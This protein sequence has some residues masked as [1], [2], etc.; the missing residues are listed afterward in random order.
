MRVRC[1]HCHN[2][3][4][5]V[6][7]S[8]LSDIPCPTCGSSFSLVGGTET[9]QTHG[10]QKKTLGHFELA[11][12][13]GVGAHGEVWR[14][15]DMRL[16]RTV[17]VKIPRK[18]RLNPDEAEKFLR[19]ARAAAQ[20]KHPSIVSVHE[21]GREDGQVYIVSDY[22]EG[23]TLADRLLIGPLSAHESARLCATIAAAL[24]H[25]HEAGVVHRDLKPSNI[26]LDAQN[27]PHVTDF[28]LAKREAG[29]ITM[30][31]AGQMLGTPAY[32]SPE[33][34]KGAAHD[35]DRRSDIYSLG[36]IV[37]ELLTGE[38][39]FRGNQRM[40][41]HQVINEDAPSPRKL[42]VSVPRDLE[43]ICLRCL[44][45]DPARRFPDAKELGDELRRFLNG[46]PIHSRP[47]GYTARAWR[48]CARNRVVSAA[49]ATVLVTLLAAFVLVTVAFRKERDARLRS[50][51]RFQLA[52]DLVDE[53]MT[54]ISE[55]P[56]LK[57]VG[58][59][60]VRLDILRKVCEFYDRSAKEFPDNNGISAERGMAYGRLADL[61]RLMSRPQEA[62]MNYVKALEIL[63]PFG[64]DPAANPE[65]LEA[66]E[67]TLL[68]YG[69]LHRT[70]G[71]LT[72]AEE[73][74]RE[75]AEVYSNLIDRFPD[76]TEYQ[77]VLGGIHINL[78]NVISDIPR[79]AEAEEEYK[80]A[81][82]IFE[83]IVTEKPD[84]EYL[85]VMAMLRNNLGILYRQTDRLPEAEQMY[86]QA[87]ESR[88]Q[89]VESASDNSQYRDHL[90]QSLNNLAIFFLLTD[91][92]LEE[93]EDHL[94]EAARIRRGLMQEHPDMPNY[95]NGLNGIRRNLGKLYAQT[96]RA[97]EAIKIHE[98]SISD[99]QQMVELFPDVP[100]F[101]M[102][103]AF[104]LRNLADI[105]T[106][107]VRH[108]PAEALLLES[109]QIL[110]D[111][112]TQYPDATFYRDGL[113]A[114]NL[115]LGTCRFNLQQFEAAATAYETAIRTW[116][117]LDEANS[118]LT[119][120]INQGIAQS[121]SGRLKHA[122]K[123]TDEALSLYGLAI[124]LFEAVPEEHPEY[125]RARA[126]LV[127]SL[128]E[129]ASVL[130]DLDR[131][132]EAS[133]DWDRAIEVAGVQG[134][135]LELVQSLLSWARDGWHQE[136]SAIATVLAD[137]SGDD[138]NTLYN[139]ACILAQA[140]VAAEQDKSLE[141]DSR[142][143][144]SKHYSAA[145]IER[146]RELHQ[147]GFFDEPDNR[148]LLS[149]DTDLEL[150]RELPEFKQLVESLGAST[151]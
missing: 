149:A 48:W 82:S 32:M 112:G 87:L 55:D 46:Q 54:G 30:T 104:Q 124:S 21:V 5:L 90:A 4:E 133:E 76:N 73:R 70:N 62:E 72:E 84:V 115:K 95:Q 105:H 146:L 42:D 144:L 39:P 96:G 122:Q 140:F 83:G 27:E 18:D 14:A 79:Y 118:L 121:L 74:F 107:Y 41:L 134:A 102:N 81:L 49:T 66:L 123:R 15:N 65:H 130:K 145:A 50:E 38:R 20:L 136:A 117:E 3:I 43:T 17:A 97:E 127:Q 120:R 113:A 142:T 116:Q 77:G 68:H 51:Q 111:L 151:Q 128:G 92:R 108:Q 26:I 114:T 88:R 132:A 6:D 129:R 60:A 13:L 57:S 1:P 106:T 58:A 45:K 110:A 150:L 28:G 61:H 137:S 80:T 94:L 148:G 9:T 135:S 22:V 71:R 16:D 85:S 100:T 78:G 2:P 10:A 69:V 25:A 64:Q 59:E 86:R 24:H 34:A 98:E 138:T 8:S 52:R 36:V 89:A 101:Q 19:E 126:Q 103:L 139:V 141:V 11:Q 7:D 119:Y 91:Q 23:V 67:T 93:C 33:Q 147:Q 40:L 47:I 109:A 29:E 31:V 44:E 125:L 143:E 63:R 53:N 12:R 131:T 75:A 99:Y 37:F 35:A 56:R